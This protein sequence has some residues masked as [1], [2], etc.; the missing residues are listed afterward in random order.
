MTPTANPSFH[1]KAG[2]AALHVT[3]VGTGRPL[4]YLHGIDGT[5][6]S[7]EFVKL[8]GEH[9]EVIVPDHPGFGRSEIPPWLESIHDLATS[10]CNIWMSLESR[11]SMS[12]RIPWVRGSHLRWRCAAARD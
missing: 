12:C 1:Q 4:L 5:R 6:S 3:R 10:I 11:K 2:T 7:G 9:A 8:L